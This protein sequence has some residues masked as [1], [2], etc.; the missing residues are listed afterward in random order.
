MKYT[1]KILFGLTLFSSSCGHETKVSVPDNP[2]IIS[3]SDSINHEKEIVISESHHS[4]D[5]IA[6]DTEPP[7][8]YPCEFEFYHLGEIRVSDIRSEEIQC[9][10]G[11]DSRLH[12]C[13]WVY[14][15]H[16]YNQWASDSLITEYRMHIVDLDSSEIEMT[17]DFLRSRL[18]KDHII[19]TTIADRKNETF[20]TIWDPSHTGKYQKPKQWIE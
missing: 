2:T 15:E 20:K 18:F 9:G 19:A 16:I 17:S 3:S 11:W 13:S 1:I 7:F 6:L 5:S 14:G 10:K 8:K 12:S 4:I